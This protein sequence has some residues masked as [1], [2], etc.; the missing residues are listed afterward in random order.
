MRIFTFSRFLAVAAVAFTVAALSACATTN[1]GVKRGQV[2]KLP[3]SKQH[4]FVRVSEPGNNTA[5]HKTVNPNLRQ[6]NQASST[7]T[8]NQ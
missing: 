4:Q 7:P 3:G 2:R 6:G 5:P 1:A 8:N